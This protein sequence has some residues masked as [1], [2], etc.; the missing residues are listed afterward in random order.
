M[1]KARTVMPALAP[2]ENTCRSVLDYNT[3][4]IRNSKTICGL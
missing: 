3:T 4:V 2:R 1:L